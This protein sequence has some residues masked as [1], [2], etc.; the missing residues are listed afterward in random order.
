MQDCVHVVGKEF[1]LG[2]AELEVAGGPWRGLLLTVHY[3]IKELGLEL[4]G[5]F[6]LIGFRNGVS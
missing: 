6:L 1:R 4:G 3:F 2:R 5:V